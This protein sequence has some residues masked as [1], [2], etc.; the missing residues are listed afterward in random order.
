MSGRPRTS[1]A[2]GFTGSGDPK[3]A[4]LA[5]VAL[6]RRGHPVPAALLAS[7]QGAVAP[8]FALSPHHTLN[9]A[10]FSDTAWRVLEAWARR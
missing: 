1:S 8:A 6:R 2:A 9:V 4:V 5:A 3:A 7:V 10:D